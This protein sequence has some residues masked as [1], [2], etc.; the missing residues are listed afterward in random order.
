MDFHMVNSLIE[1]NQKSAN[2]EKV[3]IRS[4]IHFLTFQD[5]AESTFLI[6]EFNAFDLD[7]LFK[8]LNISFELM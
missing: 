2:E 6:L 5:A 7:S 1:Y 3:L 8:M 4:K